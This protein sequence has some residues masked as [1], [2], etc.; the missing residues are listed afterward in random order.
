MGF[1]DAD[2]INHAKNGLF[3]RGMR[4]L[5]PKITR[6]KSKLM[7][8][9]IQ[10]AQSKSIMKERRGCWR[11]VKRL[12]ALEAGRVGLHP[13]WRLQPNDACLFADSRQ[14]ANNGVAQP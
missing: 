3:I 8:K 6:A 2:G 10:D 11:A 5:A 12:A 4:F 9:Y 14:D 1:S 13:Q 7:L